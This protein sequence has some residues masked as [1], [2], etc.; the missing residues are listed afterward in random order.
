MPTYIHTYIYVFYYYFISYISRVRGETLFIKKHCLFDYCCFDICARY[1]SSSSSNI[2]VDPVVT[3]VIVDHRGVTQSFTVLPL[4]LYL[5][6][7][8]IASSIFIALY[9]FIVI[10]I[11]LSLIT[12][13]YK[14]AEI[15]DITILII[16]A[17]WICINYTY[18]IYIY[19]YIYIYVYDIEAKILA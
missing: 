6:N 5:Y 14:D 17:F 1:L 19:T 10:R 2:C 16:Y 13:H 9:D 8:V 7:T 18:T 15:R 11:V 12:L 4:R 3:L